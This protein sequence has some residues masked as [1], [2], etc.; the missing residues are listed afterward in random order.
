MTYRLFGAKPLS[1]PVKW[2]LRNKPYWN[3]NQNIEL[4]IHENESEYIVC[5]MAAILCPGGDELMYKSLPILHKPVSIT[6][7]KHSIWHAF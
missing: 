3:F 7:A 5:E 4:F 1:K 6:E 2:I